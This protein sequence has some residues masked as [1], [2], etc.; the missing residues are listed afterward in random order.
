MKIRRNDTILVITGK[1]RG[2]RGTVIRVLPKENR[3]VIEGLNIAK[4]HSKPTAKQPHGG[5]V[6]FAAPMATS[7]VMLVCG[8]CNKPTRSASKVTADGKVRICTHCQAAL[9]TETKKV[10][11]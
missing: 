10:T 7:N 9:V 4:R 3:V 2:K 11:K 6:E 1:D 8:A 5:I